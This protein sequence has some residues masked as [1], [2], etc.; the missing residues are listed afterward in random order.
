MKGA[1]FELQK[2]I[3]MVGMLSGKLF[4]V[5]IEENI[6]RAKNPNEKDTAWYRL[7]LGDGVKQFT[8]TC[9]TKWMVKV[10]PDKEVEF[11]VGQLHLFSQYDC[12]FDVD[13]TSGY[14][15]LK[16]RTFKPVAV[17]K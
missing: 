14:A 15:K 1:V 2:V 17:V 6:I 5:G 4:V 11:L 16:L 13:M 12:T 3:E 8:C 10:A 9:G 7:T